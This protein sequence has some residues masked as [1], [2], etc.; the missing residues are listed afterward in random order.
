[1][2]RTSC[3]SG[4]HTDFTLIFSSPH[5]L[6]PQLKARDLVYYP[7]SGKSWRVSTVIQLQGQHSALALG[8][9]S[10]MIT[11]SDKLSHLL[12]KKDFL[13]AFYL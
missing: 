13:K 2:Y 6:E 9:T 3:K 1:M 5:T 10:P 11:D 12:L 7:S 4:T 8:D